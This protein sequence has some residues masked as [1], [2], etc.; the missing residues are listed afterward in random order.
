MSVASIK[1]GRAFY[2]IFAEDKTNKG[3]ASAESGLRKFG[4]N[5]G[6]V[7]AAMAGFSAAALT[8]L[9]ALIKS[10]AGAGDEITDAMSVTGLSSDFLQSLK[11]A[12]ADAGVSFTALIG[13]LTK[14]NSFLTK[15]AAGNKAANKTLSELGLTIQSLMAMSPDQRFK[16]VADAIAKVPN[17][18]QRAALAVQLLGKTGAKLLPALEGGAQSLNEAMEDLKSRGL[19]MSD[20]DRK[21]AAKAEGAFLKLQLALAR[22]GQVIA[23][24]VTPA[25]LKV[26]SVIQSV[27]ES[28]VKFIDNNRTLVIWI[29][30]GIVAVGALGIVLMGLGVACIAAGSATAGLTAAISALGVV[31]G[32]ITSP[33][34]VIT[35]AIL[36]MGVAA[37]VSAYYLDQLFNGGR[38]LQFLEQSALG[39]YQAV[40]MLW[41]AIV[42][43]RWDLAGRL[44]GDGLKV[45]FYSAI[46]AIKQAWNDMVGWM[47]ATML[48][49]VKKIEAQLPQ[50]I[51]DKLGMG[52]NL[53]SLAAS[54]V[55]TFNLSDERADT[56]KAFSDLAKTAKEIAEADQQQKKRFNTASMF[57]GTDGGLMGGLAQDG[58]ISGSTGAFNSAAAAMLGRA[59]PANSIAEK[60]LDAQIAGNV[61]LEDIKDGIEELDLG[62]VAD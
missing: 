9:T 57:E 18:A 58:L 53:K 13:S 27:V 36:A 35:A 60:Q 51:S 43:G 59:A 61:L 47:V 1:A 41:A 16:A 11:F 50:W 23:A 45:G 15:A 26:M 62:L 31:V 54:A 48:D 29:T 17:S 37:A 39:A 5:I 40:R 10:F 2:E 42:N 20:E 14:F 8:G 28:V 32:V 25:F 7:G 55:P 38:G 6:I 3:L 22:V 34:F 49:A 52:K 30:G 21:L 46:L 12:A 44:I 24:A 56:M 19:I 4:A 33:V